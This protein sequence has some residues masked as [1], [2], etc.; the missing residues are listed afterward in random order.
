M[1]R[2]LA[3]M[4]IGLL[5]GGAYAGA[6]VDEDYS[7]GTTTAGYTES[8]NTRDGDDDSDMANRSTTMGN[9]WADDA[10]TAGNWG[11]YRPDLDAGT[12][13]YYTA[14]GWEWGPGGAGQ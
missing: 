3:L 14:G 12:G 4:L 11:I 13:G 1:Q 5:A 8:A 2:Y 9:L 7:D 6:W 10:T